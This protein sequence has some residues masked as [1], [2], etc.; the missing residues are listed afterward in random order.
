MGQC[1]FTSVVQLL[2]QDDSPVISIANAQRF[3]ED[4]QTGKQ[5]LG[6]ISIVSATLRRQDIDAVLPT[7]DDIPIA[8]KADGSAVEL[9]ALQTFGVRIVGYKEAPHAVFPCRHHM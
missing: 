4:E 1:E 3:V 9:P 5:S 2:I 8:A 7:H 6:R